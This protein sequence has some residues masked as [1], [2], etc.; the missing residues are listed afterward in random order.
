MPCADYNTYEEQ[1]AVC[2]LK[3]VFRNAIIVPPHRR[4]IDAFEAVKILVGKSYYNSAEI[5]IDMPTI[6]PKEGT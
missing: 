4:L 1:F 6:I 3:S 5:I 2:P